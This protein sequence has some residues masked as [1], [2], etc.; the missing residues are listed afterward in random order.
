MLSLPPLYSPFTPSSW[1]ATILLKSRYHSKIPGMKSCLLS[2][3]PQMQST[4][5]VALTSPLTTRRPFQP[6]YL[7]KKAAGTKGI[8]LLYLLAG[9][10]SIGL[11]PKRRDKYNFLN[12]KSYV[13]HDIL[14]TMPHSSLARFES[15][16][17]HTPIPSS[18]D[19]RHNPLASLHAPWVSAILDEALRQI[20]GQNHLAETH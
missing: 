18:H 4:M 10:A 13:H 5:S 14:F 8:G 16:V 3:R 15:L 20:A 12:S 1:G 17:Y 19:P 2:C 9:H 7:L 6:S 11:E